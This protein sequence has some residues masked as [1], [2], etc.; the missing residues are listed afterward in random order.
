MMLGEK[1]VVVKIDFF[2]FVEEHMWFGWW[3]RKGLIDNFSVQGWCRAV[4]PALPKWKII[5]IEHAR[6]LIVKWEEDKYW[7]DREGTLNFD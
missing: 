7:H 1:N 6:V 4:H 5:S 2:R 3:Y